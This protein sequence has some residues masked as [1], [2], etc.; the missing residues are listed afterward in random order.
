MTAE[1]LAAAV[2]EMNTI[3]AGMREQKIFDARLALL[4]GEDAGYP[5]IIQVSYDSL[6]EKPSFAFKPVENL[7]DQCVCAKQRMIFDMTGTEPIIKLGDFSFY[8]DRWIEAFQILRYCKEAKNGK[9]IHAGDKP[10]NLKLEAMCRK[11]WE[12]LHELLKRAPDMD[13]FP[14]V[15]IVQR[16]VALDVAQTQQTSSSIGGS[17]KRTSALRN[18]TLFLF[19]S[20]IDELVV[21]S[22]GVEIGCED[23]LHILISATPLMFIFRTIAAWRERHPEFF[24]TEA[25][26]C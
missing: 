3:L 5:M 15:E 13:E 1:K 17:E 20:N 22:S 25:P 7:F 2:A 19:A 21:S 11:V 10:R 8:P 16:L 23:K 24:L 14:T 4:A 9:M 26:K 18:S 6:C 12:G